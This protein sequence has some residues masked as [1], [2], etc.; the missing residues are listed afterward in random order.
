MNNL[1]KIIVALLFGLSFVSCHMTKSEKDNYLKDSKISNTQGVPKDSITFYFPTSIRLDTDIV[2][3]EIDTFMLNWFSSALYSAK[4]PILYNYY[5]GHDIYR[6]LWLRSFHRPVVI[7]LQK[8]RDNV[9]L[10]IKELNK[11]P[12]FIDWLKPTK[13]TP[14]NIL[15]NGDVDEIEWKNREKPKIEVERKADRKAEIIFNQTVKLTEKEWVEFETL[16]N[17]CSFWTSKP[18]IQTM[19]LDGS[20]WTIEGHLK[21]KYWVVIRWSPHDNFRKAGDYLIKKSRFKEEI[22]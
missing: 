16:L 18:R 17:D 10:T 12:E 20:E 13:F 3:T 7:S 22:Y 19:G 1:T 21:N 2:K 15:P 6:F 5:L 4:E 8:D 14:P 11:Q 9:W